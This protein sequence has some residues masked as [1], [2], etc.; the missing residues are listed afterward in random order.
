MACPK[1]GLPDDGPDARAELSS[2]RCLPLDSSVA[3]DIPGGRRPFDLQASQ[4]T[5][6]RAGRQDKG[7]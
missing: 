7:L 6:I 3:S 4:R 2:E 5:G 1:C